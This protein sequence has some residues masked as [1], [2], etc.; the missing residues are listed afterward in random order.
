MTRRC[1][2]I[3]TEFHCDCQRSSPASAY[4]TPRGC[5]GSAFLR[6]FGVRFVCVRGWFMR[7]GRA[8]FQRS[9]FR[10][11]G[12]FVCLASG[13]RWEG[14]ER[15]RPVNNPFGCC[16]VVSGSGH[17]LPTLPAHSAVGAGLGFGALCTATALRGFFM[18]D[19]LGLGRRQCRRPGSAKAL[20]PFRRRS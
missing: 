11:F 9:G 4:M 14:G 12:A 19:F 3:P 2:R 13:V 15:G 5:T 7:F 18:N 8:A 20:R 10:S 1:L 17:G 6:R 16:F